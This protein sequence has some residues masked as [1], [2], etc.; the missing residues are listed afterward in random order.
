MIVQDII[1][2][3]R[4]IVMIDGAGN[5][6]DR[7]IAINDLLGQLQQLSEGPSPSLSEQH[8]YVPG[9]RNCRGRSNSVSE[10][11]NYPFH[12]EIALPH[13]ARNVS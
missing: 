11:P 10:A 13:W 2:P 9:K 6:R 12:P 7:T 1:K 3:V 4:S 8:R 5:G